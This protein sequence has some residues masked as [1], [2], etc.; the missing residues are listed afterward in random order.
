MVTGG[1]FPG[2]GEGPEARH[3]A[4]RPELG[5][6][7]GTVEEDGF[8]LVRAGIG[9]LEHPAAEGHEDDRRRERGRDAD[10]PAGPEGGRRLPAF[11]QGAQEPDRFFVPGTR[12]CVPGGGQ[13]QTR[14]LVRGEVVQ[15]PLQPEHAVQLRV[16]LRVGGQGRE[17][18]GV[19][20]L[21]LPGQDGLE[22]ALLVFVHERSNSEGSRRSSSWLRMR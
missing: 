3:G 16:E 22:E 10:Q 4:L 6:G 12:G 15:L 1:K 13:G 20:A 2:P 8:P 21:D 14:V 18:V 5:G 17:Q 7:S 11:Q 19:R 9:L